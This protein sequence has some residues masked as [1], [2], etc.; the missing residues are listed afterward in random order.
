MLGFVRRCNE[1]PQKLFDMDSTKILYRD[2]PPLKRVVVDDPQ[3]Q[4]FLDQTAVFAFSALIMGQ[5]LHGS[6]Q[7]LC[8]RSKGSGQR[9]PW[10]PYD[11]R[12]ADFSALDR[13]LIGFLEPWLVG[14]WQRHQPPAGAVAPTDRSMPILIA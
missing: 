11:G 7:P 8:G 13:S 4:E 9:G 3:F 10:H 2:I 14:G 1:A 6:L 5:P 12:L